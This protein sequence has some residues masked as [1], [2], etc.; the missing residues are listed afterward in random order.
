MEVMGVEPGDAAI[1]EPAVLIIEG[2][3]RWAGGN[4]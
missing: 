2:G 3:W 4:W 1:G